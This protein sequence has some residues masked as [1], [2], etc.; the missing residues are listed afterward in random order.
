[1]VCVGC[2]FVIFC[3]VWVY[4]MVF[5]IVLSLMMACGFCGIW[6]CWVV[7][8]A[9]FVV[10]STLFGWFCCYFELVCVRFWLYYWIRFL[11]VVWCGLFVVWLDCRLNWLM[12]FAWFVIWVLFGLCLLDDLLGL[13]SLWW[14]FIWLCCLIF[15]LVCWVFVILCV[16]MVVYTCL[17]V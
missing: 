4:L 2:C 6:C 9:V 16:F 7:F 1:V 5:G 10:I 8:D 3:I 12:L 14:V 11:G 15:I 17:E 13:W